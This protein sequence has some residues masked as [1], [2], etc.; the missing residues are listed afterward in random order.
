[1][2]GKRKLPEGWSWVSI[3]NILDHTIKSPIRMG[4]F[5]SQLLKGEL[6]AE[7]ILVLGIEHV[8]NKCFNDTGVKFITD[9]KFDQLKGFE[10]EPGE[11][12]IT[13]MGTIGRT[14]VVPD[15]IRKSIIG[16]HLL[17]MKLKKDIFPEYIAWVLSYLSPVY[18]QMHLESQG[19]IMQGLNTGIVKKLSFPL[20]STYDDQVSIVNELERKMAEIEKIRQAA[21]RQKEAIATARE[22]ILREAF[23]YKEGGKL[24][25]GWKWERLIRISNNIQ[26]GIS[27]ESTPNKVG[28]QL[29]RI[30][31]IQNGKVNWNNVPFCECDSNEENLYLLADGDIVF[32]RTGATT[33]KSFL[34]KNPKHSVFAS[35]LIRVQCN[36]DLV[37]PDYLYTFFQSP[38]YWNYINRGA[39]GGTLAGF[40]ASML[41]SMNIPL[42][43]TLDDQIAM[44]DGLQ[45]KM[46][47]VEKVQQATD[48]QLA[49]IE[50]FA[51][52]I[53]REA[54][55]FE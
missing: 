9:E 18:K 44:A 48:I 40:N 22:A 12:L 38:L 45:Q 34:L 5:G 53:L 54:F 47:Q 37:Q 43:P 39:R 32:V 7:G 27:R 41:S 3:D 13:M 25:W 6:V 19:A 23:P 35:Y 42:P 28:P 8:L 20:P 33:G 50:A 46:A 51:G 30:T 24:P 49:A 29:L 16:S 2:K 11:V 4:P 14:A 21:H 17:K 31:D 15:G 10:T 36:R 26:Y 55:D 1:M 52:A